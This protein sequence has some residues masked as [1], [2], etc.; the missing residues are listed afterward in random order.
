MK[1][2]FYISSMMMAL[3]CWSCQSNLDSPQDDENGIPLSDEEIASNLVKMGRID[4]ELLIGEW[5]AIKFA[6]TSDGK[7]ISDVVNIKS[8]WLEIPVAPTGSGWEV[9]NDEADACKS[10]EAW[11]LG[12]IN[13]SRWLCSLSGNL[14]KFLFC[15]TTKIG[16][17]I[18]HEEW[19]IVYAFNNSCSFVIKGN[20]LMI[21]FT[22]DEEGKDFPSIAGN[23]KIN[24]IIFKKR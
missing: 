16:V 5:D 10:S 24:L 3:F 12:C 14:I 8:A 9:Y 2:V 7:K 22:E 4:P 17:P 6:Y 1:T 11:G 21:F 23:K 20:E 15:G 13:G 18:Q 19:D